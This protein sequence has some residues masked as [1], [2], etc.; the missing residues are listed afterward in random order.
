MSQEFMDR[1]PMAIA[2]RPPYSPDLAP[3]YF[4]LFGHVKGLLRGESFETGEQLLYADDGNLRYLE[5]SNLSRVL[6]EW[7][8]RLERCIETNGDYVVYP[9]RDI[10]ALIGFKRWVSRYHISGKHPVYLL[11]QVNQPD[12]H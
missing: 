12:K 10:L 6:L 8:T 11:F 7:M 2:A 1:N 9:K 3:S 4:Y 5:K